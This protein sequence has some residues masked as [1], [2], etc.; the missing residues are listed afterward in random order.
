MII[1]RGL[2]KRFGKIHAVKDLDLHVKKGEIHGLIGPEACGKSTILLILSTLIRPDSGSATINDIPLD[3]GR[4]IRRIIGFVPKNPHLPLEY[5]ARGL[6]R[7]IA[8]LYGVRD[9]KK[10][11]SVLKLTGLD[12]VADQTL[13]RYSQALKKNVAFAAALIHEPAILLLDE[14][15]AGL[16]PIL[17][18]RLKE[19]LFSSDRTILMAAQDLGA[20]EGICD[21]VT[22]LRSGSVII[23][24]DLT[25]LRQKIGKGVLE[26][27]L[28]DDSSNVQKLIFELEKIGAKPAASGHSIYIHFD[29]DAE[30]PNIIRTAA[31]V[32]E[33]IEAKPIK[34]SIDDIY[35][36]FHGGAKQ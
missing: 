19:F 7:F 28:A 29:S 17:Q 36:R 10:I 21:S 22:V 25:S 3:E 32:A 27:K 34:I 31:G 15:M 18:R 1:A 11:E 13:D 33:V 12:A 14:P 2:N 35:T 8:S 5:T 23:E 30:V 16:D 24:D 4:K 9:E 26:I 20:V 6:V